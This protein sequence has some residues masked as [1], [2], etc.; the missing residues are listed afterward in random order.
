MKIKMKH[1]STGMVIDV[2]L[3]K[4]SKEARKRIADHEWIFYRVVDLKEMM[5]ALRQLDELNIGEDV[6]EDDND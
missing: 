6:E 2:E 4:T 3:G 5:D 1:Q